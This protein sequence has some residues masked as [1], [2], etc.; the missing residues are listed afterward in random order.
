MKPL[1]VG[2]YNE[3]K[4]V[5]EVPFGLYLDTSEGEVLL[6]K[7]YVPIDTVVGEIIKVFIYTDSEDR[8]IATTLIP[9]AVLDNFACLNVDMLQVLGHFWNGV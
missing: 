4:I 5:K 3:L 2:R 9:L 8:L 7:K 6:P 1:E